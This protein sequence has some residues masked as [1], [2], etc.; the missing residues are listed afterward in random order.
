MAPDSPRPVDQPAAADVDAMENTGD[1]QAGQ[2]EALTKSGP[3]R[4]LAGPR[5]SDQLSVLQTEN[6]VVRSIEDAVSVRVVD[7]VFAGVVE[8][9][10][11]FIIKHQRGIGPGATSERGVRF[12]VFGNTCW[13]S[14]TGGLLFLSAVFA[15]IQCDRKRR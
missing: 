6:A 4:R 8:A 3:A 1:G 2:I 5:P 14:A 10:A 12:Q 13:N 7:D 15:Q 9:V 11:V